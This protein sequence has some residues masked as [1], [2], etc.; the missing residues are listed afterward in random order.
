M[1][2]GIGQDVWG[3]GLRLHFQNILDP[4]TRELDRNLCGAI[5]WGSV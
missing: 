1:G 3:V 5:L 2:M 4:H